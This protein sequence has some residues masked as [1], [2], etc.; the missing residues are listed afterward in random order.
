MT[1]GHTALVL[2]AGGSTRLGR[3]K[4]LLTRD[5]ETLVH[6]AV[7]LALDTAPSHALVVV[8]ADRDAVE[9]A[10]GELPCDIVFNPHWSTGLASSLQ[11]AAAFVSGSSVLVVTC[12]QPA[13][14][15]EH[16]QA[17]LLG[18]A[19]TPSRCAATRHGDALGVPA[20]VPGKWFAELSG[21]QADRGF[22]ARLLALDAGSLFILE[23][24]VLDFDI[25]MPADID[26]AISRGWL[27]P[28]NAC[29]A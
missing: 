24:P 20:V 21:L 11:A 4:Q 5:G 8:G 3:A 29:T 12:D 25:D 22:G 15:A 14:A 19:T 17:L 2:A 13:L 28:P 10:I 16:L 9:A 26:T 6:R 23:A 1:A 18:A 7:R 27:D